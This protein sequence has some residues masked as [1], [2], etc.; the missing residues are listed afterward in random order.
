MSEVP[1]A[2][3]PR[4]RRTRW[5][6][7]GVMAALWAGAAGAVI[8]ATRREDAEATGAFTPSAH[9]DLTQLRYVIG[10]LPE[11]YSSRMGV[12][13]EAAV[14]PSPADA[15]LSAPSAAYATPD[16]PSAPRV[17]VT[18]SDEA[19]EPGFVYLDQTT[20]VVESQFDGRRA[21]CG[22]FEVLADLDVG[23][24][25][26]WCY[27]DAEPEMVMLRSE[28]LGIEDTVAML[29]GLQFEGEEP[30][31]DPAVLPEGMELID[32]YGAAGPDQ[33]ATSL[34]RYAGPC[35]TNLS[36]VIAW[37]DEMDLATA[38]LESR[39]WT[40]V[41]I[42]GEPGHLSVGG[43][44]AST[45]VWEADGRAFQ[46]SAMSDGEVDLLAIANSVHAATPEEWAALNVQQPAPTLPA[47]SS[48]AATDTVDALQVTEELGTGGGTV[49][50]QSAI[51]D[52]GVATV[53]WDDDRAIVTTGAG[54]EIWACAVP[55]TVRIV[56]IDSEI[57]DGELRAH[58]AMATVI[59][60][61]P[62]YLDVTSTDGTVVHTELVPMPGSTDAHIALVELPD[63][64]VAAA[65]VTDT[66]GTVIRT[67]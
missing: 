37:D 63:G 48:S 13:A 51:G 26:V 20:G 33:Y 40:I 47:L 22:N 45:L 56:P 16:D 53:A 12:S 8:V 24:E 34:A 21:A 3:S 15:P 2:P 6:L 28:G 66:L 41:D 18:A 36:L 10:D 31:L 25:Q 17:W 9:A 27:I 5:I 58:G 7:L 54:E 1:P 44:N 42:G 61:G 38:R 52:S 29:Q 67:L 11:G 39:E 46:L 32:A 30:R 4:P 60:H 35:T 62:R 49:Q 55:M 50:L 65:Q 57:V 43:R 19:L 64:L 14:P 59:G 23:P